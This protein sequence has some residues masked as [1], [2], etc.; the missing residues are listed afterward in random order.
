MDRRMY[1]YYRVASAVTTPYRDLSDSSSESAAGYR[2]L[3]RPRRVFLCCV[4]ALIY[5]RVMF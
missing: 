2:K 5:L 1:Y 4:A 3:P